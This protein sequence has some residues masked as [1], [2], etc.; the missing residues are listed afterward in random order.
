MSTQPDETAPTPAEA[1][2]RLEQALF[3]IRRVIA[4]PGRDARARARLPARAGHLLIEGVPGLA[5][6]LTI[7]TT[8]GV[9]GGTFQRVQFTPDLVPSDLVGTRIYRAGE[10][11]LR[12]RARPGL[13]QLPARGR[14]QPR[15]REGAVG[16][17]R[18]DA[19]APGD[20]RPHDV[21][22]PGPV[23]R[24]WRR[25]TRSSPRARTRCPR[26][27]STASCSRSLVDY[28]A[29]DE[30]LT[31]VQRSLD[32]RAG[33]APG[34]LARRA[35]RR[36]SARCATVYVDPALDQLRR[37]RS[38][39]RRATR[40]STASPEL[41]DYVAYGASPRG[42]I[43]LVQAARALALIRGRDYVL[44]EDLQALA[45]DALRHRLVLS[46]QALAEE[47]S[48]DAILDAVLAAVPRAADRP[49]ARERRVRSLARPRASRRPTG[50]GPGRCR[51]ALLRALDLTIGRRVE[52]LLAGD[53][54]SALLGDGSELA[55]VRPYEPGDD[56]RRI[57]WNV[58]ARTGEP[59][60]RV[61]LAERVLVTWLVL[62]TSPSMAFGTADRRKADVAEGV[63]LAR[64]PRGDAARQPARPRHVRRRRA[65]V[66][67][68]PRQ[69]RRGLLGLLAALREDD[70]GEARAA[71]PR[72]ARR[73]AAR[74]RSRASARSSSSSPTSAAR[75]TGG[76]RCSSSP[77][78]TTWSRSRSATRASRSC[79]TSASSGSSIPR[80]AG[81][82]A[83]TPA[84]ARLRERFAAAAAEERRRLA[85]DARVGGVRHV[86][87]S[88]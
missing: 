69:G 12:H 83:S 52:G 76:G 11:T 88:T 31:V 55:Q 29:H 32:R 42:P 33:A 27:R 7:K 17:A 67:R 75:S 19:G 65:A 45:R 36:C 38:R 51:T 23:P 43:S 2:E 10:G 46:Y 9:L 34:A 54:R 28:P 47:V 72:S 48:A 18:G 13:L 56:V 85:R 86:V 87:L 74:A 21:P 16:A 64:R 78:A 40:P 60:V 57:D 30:E 70:A 58:T 24:A 3:E 62:D 26:R 37:R 77:A 84:S 71:R 63:A 20:D 80:P 8:A 49:R 15:A 73:S 39:P 5:K 44:A 35:R 41:A 61:Q 4:G 82:C 1:K 22:R 14:D 6:T 50:P 79:R 53:Y 66:A 68:P 59:H 81:S 25:R